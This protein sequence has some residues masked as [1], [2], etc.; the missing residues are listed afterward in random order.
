[1]VETKYNINSVKSKAVASVEQGSP[2]AMSHPHKE[3]KAMK[4]I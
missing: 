1:M 3:L 4:T 2:S